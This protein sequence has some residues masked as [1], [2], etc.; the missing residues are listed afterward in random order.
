MRYTEEDIERILQEDLEPDHSRLVLSKLLI[1][2]LVCLAVLLFLDSVF[3]FET[4]VVREYRIAPGETLQ[5]NANDV[6]YV[7]PIG[8]ATLAFSENPTGY[9]E[10]T[11][12]I[13]Y[14][15]NQDITAFAHGDQP[16]TIRIIKRDGDTLTVR[17]TTF[18]PVSRKTGR[19]QGDTDTVMRV[20]CTGAKPCDRPP[21]VVL[22]WI[23]FGDDPLKKER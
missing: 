18:E 10:K 5:G 19:P 6:R 1:G 3:T 21:Q 4:D 23:C 20:D 12:T 7:G 17:V 9:E 16:V 8:G 22:S 13:T 15:P 11:T 2:G 14:K